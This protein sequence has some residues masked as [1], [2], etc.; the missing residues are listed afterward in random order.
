[1][2]VS[3]LSK[4]ILK[5]KKYKSPHTVV[6]KN[7]CNCLKK[8]FSGLEL[9]HCFVYLGCI[10]CHPLKGRFIDFIKSLYSQNNLDCT[11]RLIDSLDEL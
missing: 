10:W 7:K 1:M 5:K 6:S 8:Y 11:G 3:L 2:T 9:T 4:M